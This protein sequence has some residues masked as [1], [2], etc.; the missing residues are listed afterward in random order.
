MD[1]INF[2]N[3]VTPP[4]FAEPSNKTSQYNCFAGK[5][6]SRSDRVTL[7]ENPSAPNRLKMSLLF[8]SASQNSEN[9]TTASRLAYTDNH[10]NRTVAVSHRFKTVGENDFSLHT[11]C[12]DGNMDLVLELLTSDADVTVTSANGQTPLHLACLKGH[13]NIVKILLEKGASVD[14]RNNVGDTPLHIACGLGH[15]D[16]VQA[17]LEN[18]ADINM[19]LAYGQTPLHL[20]SLKGH[21]DIVKIL[22]EKG[23]SVDV[24]N[25]VGDTPLHI[26]CGLGHADIVRTLLD[27]GADINM[28]LAYGVTPLHLAC[29]KGIRMLFEY[30][31]TVVLVLR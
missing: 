6:A 4:A 3:D 9:P 23:A 29:Y 25:N 22:L 7:P 26:A 15:T 12:A 8:D 16:I 13:T 5:F 2:R 10:S 30:S 18:G 11:A 28:A 19:A 17:L 21:T 20:A 27:S 14:V 24:R 31:S 1:S